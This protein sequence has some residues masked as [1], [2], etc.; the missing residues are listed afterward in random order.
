MVGIGLVVAAVLVILAVDYATWKKRRLATPASTANRPFQLRPPI[1]GRWSFGAHRQLLVFG[2]AFVL[3]LLSSLLN[4]RFPA[5]NNYVFLAYQ[6]L[7]GALSSPQDVGAGVD[8]LVFHGRWFIIEAPMPAVIMLPSVM[9][10]G[11]HANQEVMCALC[12]AIAV[13]AAD[14]M[15]GR[16]GIGEPARLWTVVF[17]AMGNVLWWCSANGAVWMFAHVSAVMFLFLMLAEW[18]G[19]RRPW[20]VGL[21]FACAILCR[22]PVAVGTLPFIIW[23]LWEDDR[24][25]FRNVASAALGAVPLLALYGFYNYLRWGSLADIGYTLFYHMDHLGSPVGSPFALRHVISNLYVYFVRPPHFQMNPPFVSFD[26]F[27]VAVT[28]IS[29]AL[30]LIFNAPKNREMLMLFAAATL[31]AI[32]SLL[33]YNTGGVQFGTRH[34]LD[35]MPFLI[36]LLGRAIQRTPAAIAGALILYSV[37]IN[38]LGVLFFSNEL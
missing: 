25:R 28:L 6:W 10:F 21:L 33:Y 8:D 36:P 11:L 31:V 29:P 15:L 3:Y 14:T 12:G 9:L 23:M 26:K 5:Y 35:F 37:A 38:A 16:L 32:P 13:A 20:L 4:H 2:L 17:G 19:A 22:L 27:G 24:R 1:L 34:T 30:L 18:Y 7:H